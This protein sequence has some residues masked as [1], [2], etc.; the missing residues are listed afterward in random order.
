MAHTVAMEAINLSS[1]R[2]ALPSAAPCFSSDSNARYGG[3][4]GVTG[5]I[6]PTIMTHTLTVCV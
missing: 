3:H 2:L 6:W 1:Y 5:V 4:C